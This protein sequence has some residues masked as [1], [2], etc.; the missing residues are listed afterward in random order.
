V[1]VADTHAGR[2]CALD[3]GCAVIKGD[4]SG[5]GCVAFF[6]SAGCEITV[7]PADNASLA[8]RNILMA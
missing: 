7:D 2:A 6:H 5:A 3:Q 4:M 1:G 8:F